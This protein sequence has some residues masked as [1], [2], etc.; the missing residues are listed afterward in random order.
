MECCSDSVAEDVCLA[1][2]LA[3]FVYIMNMNPGYIV[4]LKGLFY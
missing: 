3:M 4:Y 1:P 2:V